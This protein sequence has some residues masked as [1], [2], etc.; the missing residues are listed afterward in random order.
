MIA[1]CKKEECTG[2]ASCLNVCKYGAIRMTPDE[3][4]FSYP[5]IDGKKC[6]DCQA[7]QKVCPANKRGSSSARPLEIYSGWSIDEDVR[8]K[9]SSGGAFTVLAEYVLNSE[10]VVFGCMLNEHLV[11]VHDYIEKVEDIEKLRGSKYVQSEIKY[12]YL[13][14]KEF[15]NEGRLV[16]FSGTPCQISGLNAFLRRD[17]ENLITVDIICHGVPS[18]MLFEDYKRYIKEEKK[19]TEIRNIQFRDKKKS[20]ILFNIKIQGI[21]KSTNEGKVYYGGWLKDK[22]IRGFLSDNFLR[23]SCYHCKYSNI[24]RISDFT[25]ADWWG[26]MPQKDEDYSFLRKGVSSIACNTSKS[27]KLWGMLKEKFI[28]RRRTE[29]EYLRSNPSLTHA[30]AIPETRTSFWFDYRNKGFKYVANKYMQTKKMTLRQHI[31][32]NGADTFAKRLFVKVLYKYERVL[33][34]FHLSFL[35]I[36]Y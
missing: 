14:A 31:C 11:A 35:D 6:I 3:E 9:S 30:F 12:N 4:G 24:Q 22:W 33:Q 23:K 1:I 18:P 10:G 29:R 26:Y 16:L 2:C 15:L 5:L 8:M 32:V 21:D 19:I 7:C 27:V 34:L 36:K 17:Y 13:K 20:W 28:Y 25:I